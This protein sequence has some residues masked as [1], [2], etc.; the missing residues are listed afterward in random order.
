MAEIY[1][2]NRSY[3]SPNKIMIDKKPLAS[4]YFK[5]SIIEYTTDY[6]DYILNYGWC[7]DLWFSDCGRKGF[8]TW[9]EN[10]SY[11]VGIKDQNIMIKLEIVDVPL[12][13]RG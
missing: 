9:N 2:V 12:L 6:C 7:E 11:F 13:F 1:V 10:D 3:I 5:E 4:S 8:E